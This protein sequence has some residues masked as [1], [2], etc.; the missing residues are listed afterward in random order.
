MEKNLEEIRKVENLV[1]D[2]RGPYAIVESDRP[3]VVYAREAYE[4]LTGCTL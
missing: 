1:E 4:K 2:L 3:S